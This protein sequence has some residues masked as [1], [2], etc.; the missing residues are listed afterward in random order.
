[1]GP[2]L[3][4]LPCGGL[5]VQQVAMVITDLLPVWQSTANV[6]SRRPGLL[7]S[8]RGQRKGYQDDAIRGNGETYLTRVVRQMTTDCPTGIVEG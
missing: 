4:S 5:P 3:S 2:V 1:M 8:L 7:A 6:V